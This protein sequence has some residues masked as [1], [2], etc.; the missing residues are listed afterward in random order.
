MADELTVNTKKQLYYRPGLYSFEKMSF[1]LNT[2]KNIDYINYIEKKSIREKVPLDQYIILFDKNLKERISGMG[3]RSGSG[4]DLS[5]EVSMKHDISKIE[6]TKRIHQLACFRSFVN[7]ILKQFYYNNILTVDLNNEI[8]LDYFTPSDLISMLK[9]VIQQMFIID[10]LSEEQLTNYK[11]SMKYYQFNLSSSHDE[12]SKQP[13]VHCM[14]VYLKYIYDHL[15]TLQNKIN[16]T[17]KPDYPNQTDIHN[18]SMF[19]VSDSFEENCILLISSD[20]PEWIEYV[21]R[22]TGF[23][24]EC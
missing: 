7:T 14:K 13:N 11:Y 4:S 6:Y 10:S 12:Q 17:N 5:M 23:F 8:M 16:D 21:Q 18:V 2:N 20:I 15:L 1:E 19:N 9:S 3:S 22:W 24:E